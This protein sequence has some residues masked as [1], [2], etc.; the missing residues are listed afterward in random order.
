PG[1]PDGGVEL[2]VRDW[3]GTLAGIATADPSLVDLPEP[4]P[5]S[6]A[7][8]PGTGERRV[9]V[10][11]TGGICDSWL[12]LAIAADGRTLTLHEPQRPGCDAMGIGRSVELRFEGAVD[13]AAFTGSQARDAIAVTDINPTVVAFADPLH[14]WV[15]GTTERGEAVIEETRDGGVTWDVMSLGAG[16][17]S[18]IAV[19]GDAAVAGRLCPEATP[20][21]GPGTFRLDRDG[22]W[23]AEASDRPLALDFAGD[24][25]IGAFLVPGRASLSGLPIPDVRV[26][27]DGFNWTGT[28]NPCGAM[29]LVDVAIGP[30][31]RP[32]AL[33][34]GQGAGGGQRK[35]LYRAGAA[36]E[37]WVVLSTTEAGGLPMN[38]TGVRVDFSGTVTGWMWGFRTPLLAT[39]DGGKTWQAVTGPG[40]G[41][42]AITVGASTL[43]NGAGYQLVVDPDRDATTLSWTADGSTWQNRFAWPIHVLCCG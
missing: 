32:L 10:A 31:A 14:G 26:T 16:T 23:A 36:G 22:E 27:D 25:G 4:G 15:G 34:A 40:D 43:G 1:P 42:V 28:T 3:S 6:L 21:C 12:N 33:C 7:I 38:G 17:V 35:A 39:A 41:D 29:D 30:D 37:P 20:E 11:W 18:D 2:S 8:G 19:A 9:T 5:R 13:P 24:D